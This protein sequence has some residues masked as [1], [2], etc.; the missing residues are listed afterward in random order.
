MKTYKKSR[1]ETTMIQ[2]NKEEEIN[3]QNKIIEMLERLLILCGR[4]RDEELNLNV[5]DLI[6]DIKDEI[7]KQ[8]S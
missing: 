7:N 8:Y 3:D 6:K 1:K 2:K 5:C 4:I